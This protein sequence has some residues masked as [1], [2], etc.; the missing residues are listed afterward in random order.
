MG[1]SHFFIANTY[2]KE[3]FEFWN[4][5]DL[6]ALALVPPMELS[7]ALA[8]TGRE[9]ILKKLPSVLLFYIP[10]FIILFLLWNTNLLE[11]NDFSQAILTPWGYFIKPGEY[12]NLFT[13]YHIAYY[14]PAY[15]LM[16]RFYQITKDK[17]KKKQA[18]LIIIAISI[19]TIGGVLFQGILPGVF[20]LPAFP[21]SSP[22]V[23]ITNL[24]ITYAMLKYSLTI[25][26]PVVLASLVF[27]TMKEGVLG[28][29]QLF[30]I[31]YLNHGALKL[32][33]YPFETI[34]GA[35][36]KTFF[37]DEVFYNK[38]TQQITNW[39]DSQPFIQIEE[40]KITTYE[41]KEIFVSLSVAKIEN[42][43]KT[44]LGYALVISDITEIKKYASTLE[45]L[46][47][48]LE[49]MVY[50]RTEG[51]IAERDKLFFILSGITDAIIAVDRSR[52]IV[53]FNKS[54]EKLFGV[55]APEVLGKPIDKVIKIFDNNEE[56][57]VEDYAPI[58]R[59]DFE[60]VLFKKDGLKIIRPH[61]DNNVQQDEIYANII[62]GK[63][64]EGE[65][66]NL[67]C[68][69]TFHDV[70]E[71]KHLEKTKH[72]FVITASH[73]LRTPLTSIIA[74][75]SVF[76]SE[77]NKILNDRQRLFLNRTMISAKLLKGLIKR[78]IIVSQI[79]TG[80]MSLDIQ[81]ID[82]IPYVENIVNDF[83]EQALDK[84]IELSYLYPQYSLQKVLADKIR[85]GEVISNLLDNAIKYTS[86]EGKVKICIEEKDN[87]I[88]TRIEDTGEGIPK[89][90]LPYLFTKFFRTSD[91][92]VA[93]SVRTGLGLYITKAIVEMHGGKIWA[94]S[95]FGKGS[96]FS[97]SLKTKLA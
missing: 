60:G 15:I 33:G 86:E 41:K 47:V 42:A 8:F 84:K 54:A 19:P 5:W 97:F 91:A 87:Y 77:N 80:N 73:Q 63:I 25:F 49:K 48:N 37:Q 56:L 50:E 95:T 24:I 65:N 4:Y 52:K 89:E 2:S 34:V 59:D 90:A 32:L 1:I 69:L 17:L 45:E 36:L 53:T 79:E 18:L 38:L 67:G 21:A 13:A 44:I 88:V 55:Y 7:Y 81:P 40:G 93:E 30:T 71:E 3:V 92:L 26:N 85:I 43:D 70:T 51:Y 61:K 16:L 14:I 35:P 94:D 72:D 22:L 64:K 12:L 96:T 11:V 68:I 39:P 28:I 75:L 29:S 9:E 78:L 76:M 66:V 23:T 27:Q 6:F 20:S 57:R 46:T 10:A 82:W 74:Y 31:E 83:R 58:K 62:S